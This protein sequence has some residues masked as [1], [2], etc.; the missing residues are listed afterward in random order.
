LSR[1]KF[2]FGHE[3]FQFHRE[4][5]KKNKFRDAKK[6]HKLELENVCI[7][8]R[9]RKSRDIEIAFVDGSELEIPIWVM[10]REI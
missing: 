1:E 6:L 4:K 8:S 2:P 3:K 9:E 5:E 7:L 10:Q